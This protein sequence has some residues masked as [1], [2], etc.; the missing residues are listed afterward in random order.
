MSLVLSVYVFLLLEVLLLQ[1]FED[2]LKYMRVLLSVFVCLGVFSAQLC[3]KRPI[4]ERG[5]YRSKYYAFR[6]PFV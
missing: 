4:T 2:F 6:G 3:E 1:V 5:I